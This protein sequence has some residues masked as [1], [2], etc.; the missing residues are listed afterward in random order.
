[1]DQ[2][3]DWGS[4]VAR[5]ATCRAGA[6]A[7]L[8]TAPGDRGDLRRFV[9]AGARG[10]T[11]E[12]RKVHQRGLLAQVGDER[13]VLSVRGPASTTD[14]V[15]RSGEASRLAAFDVD[16]PDAREFVAV[17]A[18]VD[19]PG[20]VADLPGGRVL[21]LA[22]E[23]SLLTA[24]GQEQ[25][26]FAVGRPLGVAGAVG[27]VGELMGLAPVE[28]HDPDL[29]FARSVGDEEE[30]AAV[31]RKT[32]ARVVALRRCEL[33]RPA[34]LEGDAPQ[35]AGVLVVFDRPADVNDGFTV[36]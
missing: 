14:V 8:K 22:D 33:L 1:L 36:R 32:R 2:P 17:A 4:P 16:D 11:P 13:D 7:A 10:E 6:Q 5:R 26:P 28:G 21:G 19:L 23:K 24:A 25:D 15:C 27:K 35:T 18:A 20:V 34:A 9:L 3:G 30:T 31:G 29:G 12:L